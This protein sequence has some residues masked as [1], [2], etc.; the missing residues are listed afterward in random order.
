LGCHGWGCRLGRTP[1]RV[2]RRRQLA[3]RCADV[4][5]CDRLIQSEAIGGSRNYRQTRHDRPDARSAPSGA[6][7][8]VYFPFST[9][10]RVARLR[11]GQP[12]DDPASAFDV[13]LAVWSVARSMRCSSRWRANWGGS[14]DDVSSH[15]MTRPPSPAILPCECE[16]WIRLRALTRDPAISSATASI[17]PSDRVMHHRAAWRG[18][19]LRRSDTRGLPGDFDPPSFLFLRPAALLGFSAL[20]RFAPADG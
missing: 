11:G 17:V 10:S 3:L 15:E 13:A 7:L 9:R 5:T 6:S 18:V 14:F 8:E 4:L 16:R 12:P 20:R 2:D 1:F 19:P